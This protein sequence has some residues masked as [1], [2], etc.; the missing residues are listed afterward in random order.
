MWNALRNNPLGPR[1]FSTFVNFN[2]PYTGSVDPLVVKLSA[3]ETIVEIVEYPWLRN[4][5]GSIHALALGNAGE[6]S[7][8]LLA[9]TAAE[10][11]KG[12]AIVNSI[13]LNFTKKGRGKITFH[14]A[15]S[16]EQI[17]QLK[18]LATKASEGK[19]EQL[20]LNI[21]VKFTD[22][23]KDEIGTLQANW[24]VRTK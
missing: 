5:F 18:E 22:S 21:L 24:V 12:R 16:P 10:A 2:A 23:K 1:L 3:V 17:Q 9:V 11:F 13:S 6:L 15:L 19:S 14:A 8:G 7:S 20:D 4:P